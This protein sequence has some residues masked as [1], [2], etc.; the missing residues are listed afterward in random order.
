M[1][2]PGTT[3]VY[4]YFE[5]RGGKF[6]STVF[7]GLQYLL[8]KWCLGQVVTEQKI[9]E[10]KE[11]FKSHL[12]HDYFNA[13]GWNHIL[14][15]H[16]GHLPLRIKAIPEGT[17]VPTRN[18]LFTVENT[19]P[20]VP[21]LT[22]YMETL[23]SQV[24][25]P[26]TVAT[27]SR[28][29]KELLK[30]YLM[31]TSET[32]DGLSLMLHDFGFRGVSSVE[33]AGIGG[34]AHLVNFEGTDTVPGV[35][36]ARKYYHENMAGHSGPASEHSTITSWGKDGE[37]DA[38]RN[39]LEN[40]SFGPVS[41]VSDS[42]DLYKCCQEIWGSQL[43][44]MILR[45]DKRNAPLL[46]R[47]DSGDPPMV[48]VEVLNILGREFGT[49]INS[50]GYRVLPPCLKVLQGDGINYETLSVILENM[51]RHKWSAENVVYGSGGALLQKLD[52]DTQ[53]CAYKCS[54]IE[55]NGQGVNVFKQPVTDPG[56]TSKKGLLTLEQNNDQFRTIEEG[57]GD[58]KK[59]LL[60]LVYENG[61][62]FQDYTFSEVKNNANSELP[63]MI[64][65]PFMD[66]FS[67]IAS[68]NNYK[69]CCSCIP[70]PFRRK[71]FPTT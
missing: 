12:D 71:V 48:V 20:H 8:K 34:A 36:M 66:E 62:L 45:R 30:N 41:G 4:S 56:K 42:Y 10:A 24:W 9:E 3:T 35:L 1:Y 16:N 61:K 47:P 33:S 63:V 17:I 13:D 15:T 46:V 38:C 39:L 69:H 37:A 2:P 54:Y 21:W 52:R 58:P 31:E 5:S 49:T 18:V 27:V 50:K 19:D 43:K 68:K 14:Q 44:E 25:Y 51:K 67:N 53:K 22:N 28:Y 64:K 6:P 7:F 40:Y 60:M 32:T 57:K 23:L 59:D 65:Q 70:L 29:Q 26:I 11:F 55:V